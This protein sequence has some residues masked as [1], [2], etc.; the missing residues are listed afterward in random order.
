MLVVETMD[1]E[2]Y[3]GAIKQADGSWKCGKYGNNVNV[4]PNPGHNQFWERRPVS[5]RPIPGYSA[6]CTGATISAGRPWYALRGFLLV[7]SA[8]RQYLAGRQLRP[9]HCLHI[10]MTCQEVHCVRGTDVCLTC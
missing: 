1:P 8:H 7:S 2:M 9:Q 5:V 10:S 6:W 3:P 4:H